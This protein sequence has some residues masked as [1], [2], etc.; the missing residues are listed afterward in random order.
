MVGEPLDTSQ[1]RSGPVEPGEMARAPAAG[2]IA[3]DGRSAPSFR[4]LMLHNRYLQLGGED[5][6]FDAEA[7]LLRRNDCHVDEFVLD[8]GD[9]ERL[10]KIRTAVRSIWS[11]D[12]YREIRNRLRGGRYDIVHVQN[13]FPLISPSAYYAARAEGAAVVQSLRNYRLLC[14]VG[15]LFRNN[16]IC[17]DCL[18]K[19][20]AWPGILHGCYRGSPAATS[21]VV[22]MQSINRALGTWRNLVDMYVSLSEFGKRK[23]C[24]C[25]FPSDR[26]MVKPNLVFSDIAPGDGSGNYAVF[27]GRLDE[28]KGIDTVLDA[29]DLIGD[30]VPLKIVGAG[31]KAGRVEEVAGK[32]R[33]VE[34]VGWRSKQ[35]VLEL[36]RDARVLVIAS[37]YYEPFGRV[38]VEAFSVG[39][40]VIASRLGAMAEIVADYETGLLFRPGDR[41]ALAEK[42]NWA[43][44]HPAELAAMRRR[45]RAEYD[46]KYSP[47]V[48]FGQLA[49]IYAAAIRNSRRM[50]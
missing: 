44:D 22:A 41:A 30:R 47:D 23:F 25:G 10:G 48:N 26:I 6:S 8:N 50:R 29:W 34:Y 33:N 28:V 31:P 4:V 42:V 27:V 12:T 20:V 1:I 24:E 37:E 45:A 15:T 14:P 7:E 39:T 35:E 11:L 13:F 18:G 36:I 5:F 2:D 43:A 49:D 46:R 21:A 38:I 19:A 9:V 16:R 3:R 17:Q 32:N 40:P